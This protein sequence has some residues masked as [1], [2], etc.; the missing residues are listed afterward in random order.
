MRSPTV[1]RSLPTT[2]VGIAI[3]SWLEP[4]R[5]P[6]DS[7]EPFLESKGPRQRISLVS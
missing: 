5:D 1:P 7:T 3:I 6:L 4:P 2:G